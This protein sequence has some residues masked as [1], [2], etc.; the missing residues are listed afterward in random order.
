[1]VE[2]PAPPPPPFGPPP[3][4]PEAGPPPPPAP[5]QPG[6]CPNCGAPHDPYQEY[7]LECGRR[8]P[9]LYAS[10]TE[11][12]TRESHF[13]L[14]AA[15]AALLLVALVSGAIVAVAATRGD[16]D[17]NPKTSIPVVSTGL[18]TTDTVGIITQPPTI[19]INP[20]TT[21]L[22]TTTFGTTTFSTTT[23]STTTFGTTTSS[24][25]VS[26]PAGKDGYTVVLKSVPTSEG[27]AQA[28]AAAQKARNNG[29]P[30]VGV[31]NS[32]DY[33]SL[34]PG[35]YVTFTG[36][37]DTRNQADSALPNARSR[38]FPTAYVRQVAD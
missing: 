7:C 12:W 22:G 3:P 28:D 37:Y 23:L 21:T 15:L 2:P 24:S 14:W 20:P 9:P 33:S 31:L 10:R 1:M 13:W 4:P 6:L 35:Y 17:S 30:Q 26:W 38:G 25:N 18:S 34:T 8:L 32:S 29:L 16:K 36:I 5:P 27:R 11:V 19:T